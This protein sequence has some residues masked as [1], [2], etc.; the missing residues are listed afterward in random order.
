MNS[1]DKFVIYVHAWMV[2]GTLIKIN[3]ERGK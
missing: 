1:M 2:T 3:M